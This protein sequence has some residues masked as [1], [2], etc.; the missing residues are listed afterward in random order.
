MS[1]FDRDP[2]VDR[3][4]HNIG[5]E[6][7]GHL[8]PRGV[9]L[10]YETVRQRR[11]NR[12]VAVGAVAV[13]LIGGPT[14]GFALAGGEG[15][16]PPVGGEPSVTTPAASPS[17]SPSRSAEPAPAASGT[18]TAP[19]GRISLA[20]LTR[21]KLDLPPW[22]AMATAACK[23][24]EVD[25]LGEPAYSDVDRDGAQE[26]GMLL[27]CDTQSEVTVFKVVVFDRDAAGAI[28]TL[29]QV[30]ATTFDGREGVDVRKVWSIQAAPG[31]QIRVD[32]GD[33]HPCCGVAPDVAQ[34]QWRTYGWDGQRFAQTA[35]PRAFGPNP[36]VTDLSVRA[37]EL[38]MTQQPGGNWRGTL[39]ITYRNAGPS[40][41][42]V[43]VNLAGT[44]VLGRTGGAGCSGS[45]AQGTTC[46]PAGTLAAGA[47][48]T[49]TLTF[50][51][52]GRP[53]AGTL[54]VSVSHVASDGRVYPDKQGADNRVT[55]AVRAG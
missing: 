22:P 52:A 46:N 6:V 54:D 28:V 43:E 3:L 32:V 39:S 13:A 10:V 12:V 27:R 16:A 25:F 4:L 49:L 33:Y 36:K 40:P 47:S 31:G 42:Q 48:G 44:A 19:D 35:G 8:D 17:P 51:T 15:T 20:E 45:A 29:G 50:E 24:G 38:V 34:H 14:L 7:A 11:R 18:P 53:S 30:L 1:D 55:V 21:A 26:T 37:G 9:D 41:A 5:N 2:R 23:S